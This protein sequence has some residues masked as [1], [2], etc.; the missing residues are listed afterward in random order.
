M[1]QGFLKLNEA[2][3]RRLRM[4]YHIVFVLLL[5]HFAV[6]YTFP[7]WFHNPRAQLGSFVGAG[8]HGHRSASHVIETEGDTRL[9]RGGDDPS[10]HFD[11]TTFRLEPKNLNYGIGREAF[12]ALIEPAT[13]RLAPLPRA[14][15]MSM[16]RSATSARWPWGS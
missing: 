15:R 1:N 11:I 6:V 4:M 12:P 14:L 16:C 8:T 2:S 7:G 13:A 3:R 9:L 10:M 5:M